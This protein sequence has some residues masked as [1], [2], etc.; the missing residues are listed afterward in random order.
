[1]KYYKFQKIIDTM[2]AL[3]YDYKS[4]CKSTLSKVLERKQGKTFTFEEHLSA[5]IFHNYPTNA[6]GSLL[7]TTMIT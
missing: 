7:L 2:D 5:L 1:M 3:H 6:L 4:V